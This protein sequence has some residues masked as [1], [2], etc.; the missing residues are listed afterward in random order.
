MILGMGLMM[1]LAVAFAVI[2]LAI[3]TARNVPVK[4][5]RGQ[6]SPNYDL[7]SELLIDEKPKRDPEYF[8]STDGEL[9]EIMDHADG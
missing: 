1:L 3:V 2:G 9:L 7:D 4:R 6:E 8:L 5:K